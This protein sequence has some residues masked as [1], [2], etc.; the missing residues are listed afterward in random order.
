MNEEHEAHH[1]DSKKM[2][3][4]RTGL[5]VNEEFWDEFMQVCNNSDGLS[6]LLDV[7][8]A[9]IIGWASKIKDALEMVRQADSTG[10]GDEKPK[11]KVINT[12]DFAKGMTVGSGF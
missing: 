7:P 3:A 9:S 5:N 12:G 6:E 2:H 10:E 4:I 8:S 1:Q 11:S